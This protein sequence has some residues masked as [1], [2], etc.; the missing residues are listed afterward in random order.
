MQRHAEQKDLD[1]GP[2]PFFPPSPDLPLSRHTLRGAQAV[3]SS[4]LSVSCGK[5]DW[6][7]LALRLFFFILLFFLFFFLFLGGS[8]ELPR[9]PPSR[10]LPGRC[11]HLRECPLQ[12]PGLFFMRH[13]YFPFFFPP[14]L[15]LCQRLSCKAEGVGWKLFMVVTESA[16]LPTFPRTP[17]PKW[18]KRN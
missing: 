2:L 11:R 8:P 5:I 15:P 10:P 18:I 7:D 17:I 13:F 14:I 1:R 4:L 6:R 16:I 12:E 3:G 9:A